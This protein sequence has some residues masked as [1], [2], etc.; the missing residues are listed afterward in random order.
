MTRRHD[1]H[2]GSQEEIDPSG[3]GHPAS[4]SVDKLM[5][6]CNMHA[7]R[8]GGPGGQNRNKVETAVILEH[9]PTGLR[10]EANERR[11]QGENRQEAVRRMRLELATKHRTQPSSE[12]S[13]LMRSRISGQRL[14]IAY[15]HADYPAILAECLDHLVELHYDV[16]AT[17]QRLGISNSQLLKLLH[18]HASAWQALN[19]YRIAHGMHPLR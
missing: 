5:Q 18:Q 9:R 19:Q 1:A 2:D 3:Q 10:V 8:R 4:H 7:T 12:L 14:V 16:A 6:D 11:S 13:P 17:A 15:E